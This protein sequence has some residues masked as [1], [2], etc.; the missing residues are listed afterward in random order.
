LAFVA[1]ARLTAPKGLVKLYTVEPDTST[2]LLTVFEYWELP[3]SGG[4][5]FK[6]V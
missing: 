4:F 5:R 3:E 1:E 2:P 6:I